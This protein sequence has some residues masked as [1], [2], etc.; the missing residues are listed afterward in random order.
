[1]MTDDPPALLLR[2]A[3]VE[4]TRCDVRLGGG[5]VMQIGAGLRPIG[6]ETEVIDAAGGAL[7]PGLTDHH[8][9][10]FATA[11]D[12][13]SVVCGPPSV[14][15]PAELAAALHRAVPDE[16]GW[17]RG[18]RY[19]ESVAGPLDAARLDALRQDVAVRVQHRSGALWML[20]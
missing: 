17:I 16:D 20:N 11:A 1:M 9:H 4:G 10:L 8:I 14:R 19:H 18:V 13:A 5:R 6:D 15:T 3:E 2:D 7:I 12:L